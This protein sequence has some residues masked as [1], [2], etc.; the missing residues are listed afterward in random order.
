MA[1]A[2]TGGKK[3]LGVFS[4]YALL[5]VGVLFYCMGWTS[6]MVPNGI[7]SGGLTGICTIIQF[8]TNGGIPI[9]LSFFIINTLLIIGGTI[10]LGKGFGFKTIYAYLLSSVFLYILPMY[11]SVLVV[12]L[13]EKMFVAI[14]GGLVEAL[15]ISIVLN[16]G[17]STGGMD[18][19]ALVINKFWPFSLGRIYLFFDVFIIFSIIFIPGKGVVDMLYGYLSMVAFSLAVDWFTLGPKSTYQVLVFS[20]KYQEIA[21]KLI[22]MDRG[23]T[24]LNS[25]GWY[26]GNE[27]KVL[28]VIVRK[29]AYKAVVE[30]VKSIDDKAFVSVSKATSVFG[31]GFEEIKT[32]VSGKK[33]FDG[34]KQNDKQVQ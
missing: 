25:V 4:D 23:V 6:F 34:K 11:D 7:S 21:D 10:V 12:H 13:P 19:V 18:I 33:L 14:I 26:S 22:S 17:G 31:E 5:S 29:S 8:A 27:S 24:A 30:A 15:G 1:K 28:L 32:G 16:K 9:S 20:K 3:I 2:V